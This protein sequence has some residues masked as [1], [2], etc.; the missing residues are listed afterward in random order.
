MHLYNNFFFLLYAQCG[1]FFS[2][3]YHCR[4]GGWVVPAAALCHI[5]AS[6]CGEQGEGGLGTENREKVENR[7]IREEAED[8][9]GMRHTKTLVCN[10]VTG[11]VRIVVVCRQLLQSSQSAP[12]CLTHTRRHTWSVT[13]HKQQ[14][15]YSFHCLWENKGEEKKLP[16]LCQFVLQSFIYPVIDPCHTFSFSRGAY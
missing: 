3:F 16:F 5:T 9:A 10:Q 11:A 1:W 4:G 6:P 2:F 14:P 12:Q 15:F 13:P 7:L 8:K